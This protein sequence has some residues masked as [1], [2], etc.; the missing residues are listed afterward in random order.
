MPTRISGNALLKKGQHE[1]ASASC[2]EALRLAPEHADAL[3]D[4]GDALCAQGQLDAGIASYRRAIGIRPRLPKAMNNLANALLLQ[5]QWEEAVQQYRH[6]VALDPRF[7]EAHKNLGNVLA[8]HG[9]TE[10]AIASFHAALGAK[11]DYPEAL[12]RLGVVLLEQGREE[13]ASACLRRAIAIDPDFVEGYNNLGA[14]L[15]R[16]G[17]NEEAVAV[18]RQG[19][20]RRPPHA[21][22]QSSLDV[23]LMPKERPSIQSLLLENLGAACKQM[24]LVEE[25]AEAFRRSLP[26]HPGNPLYELRIDTLCPP[27]FPSVEAIDQ[28]HQRLHAAMDRY[29]AMEIRTD[30]MEFPR[31]GCE[32]PFDAAYHGRDERAWREKFAAVFRAC[33]DAPSLRPPSAADRPRV[34]MVVTRHHEGIFLRWMRGLIENL[35]LERF[36]LSIVCARSGVEWIRFEIANPR[37][38]YLPAPHE[39]EKWVEI[40]R[41]GRFDVLHFFEVGSDSLNYFLPFLRLAPVQCVGMGTAHTTGIPHVDY[42]VSSDLIEVPEAQEH[43]TERLVR[44]ATLPTYQYRQQL[45]AGSTGFQPVEDHTGKMPVPQPVK[46]LAA[47]GLGDGRHVYLCWQNVRKLH[48]DFDRLLG[49]ILRRDPHGAIVLAKPQHEHLEA[50]L[51]DRFR[52]TMGDV[53]DRV[54]FMGRMSYQEYLNL[55]AAADV[56]LDPRPYCGCVTS[57]D[58]FSLGKPIVTFPTQYHR[59]RCTLGQ[60]RKLGILDCVAWSAEEYV[61]LALRLGTD[62]DWRRFMSKKIL[63]ASPVLFEDIEAVRQHEEFFDQAIQS[64][65]SA[66]PLPPGD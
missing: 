45:S 7:A 16:S 33:F 59:G 23:A 63:A 44:L 6:A 9:R 8:D 35:G 53:A 22:V 24:S 27:V 1:E 65:R 19:L 40:I 20:A 54:L 26:S 57:Y 3:F 42:Y 58:G 51:R 62:R 32:P 5:G 17:R 30:P 48:P 36:D 61:E 34:A 37:V 4:L 47:F 64:A 60:Y 50:A 18:C 25:A 56:L 29:G 13:E 39:F 49:G 31:I 10:E 14:L 21:E 15:A 43:Y 55:V 38:A 66:R 28:Y 41:D 2:R 12:N 52:R 11:G 46:D